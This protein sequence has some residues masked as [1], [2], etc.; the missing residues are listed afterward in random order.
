M[1]DKTSS[2]H[3]CMHACTQCS[4]VPLLLLL[5]RVATVNLT[6][7]ASKDSP[8][9]L[10]ARQCCAYY[11]YT[12]TQTR[13]IFESRTPLFDTCACVCVFASSIYLIQSSNRLV[14]RCYSF[15]SLYCS[16]ESADTTRR[17]SVTYSIYFPYF[18]YHHVTESINYYFPSLFRN[19]RNCD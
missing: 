13:R 2:R 17:D 4:R 12:T 9:F 5:L 16:C 3:A 14:L 15:E 19:H 7:R 11:F 10:F 8:L 1:K 18:P 6:L